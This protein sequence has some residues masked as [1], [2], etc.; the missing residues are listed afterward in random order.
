MLAAGKEN[1][2][3]AFRAALKAWER[4]GIEALEY[5]RNKDGVA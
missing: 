4:G 5:A 2:P 3:A 1:D